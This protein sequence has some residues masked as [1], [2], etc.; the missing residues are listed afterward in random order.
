MLL[1]L[2]TWKC[3][4]FYYAE[5]VYGRINEQSVNPQIRRPINLATS[6]SVLLFPRPLYLKT[7]GIKVCVPT[8]LLW[9][10]SK[11]IRH[12]NLSVIINKEIK[13]RIF[14]LLSFLFR[15]WWVIVEFEIA[16]CI[17]KTF[18]LSLQENA[19]KSGCENK[20]LRK[21]IGSKK[22]K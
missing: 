15:M 20:Q 5:P 2:S 14:A 3:S 8:R 4:I 11:G 9:S 22:W 1:Q 10:L 17:R 13:L 12:P 7:T 19:D 21:V 18:V 16:I 6:I